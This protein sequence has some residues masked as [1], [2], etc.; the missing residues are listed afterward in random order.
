MENILFL[1]YYLINS[2]F[3]N[4]PF[5][6]ETLS[7]LCLLNIFSDGDVGNALVAKQAS[8]KNQTQMPGKI[9]NRRATVSG[10]VTNDRNGD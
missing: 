10:R 4:V 5:S 9:R 2:V 3:S 8:D 7:N 1:F 6:I